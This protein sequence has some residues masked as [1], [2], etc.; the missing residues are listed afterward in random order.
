MKDFEQRLERLEFISTQMKE[1]GLSLSESLSL[2]EEGMDLLKGLE[3]ELESI[4]QKVQILVSSSEEDSPVFEPF[5]K[6][7]E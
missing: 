1:Q 4:E 6:E 2:F 3:K 7:D 5:N